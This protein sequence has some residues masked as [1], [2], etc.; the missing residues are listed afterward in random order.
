MRMPVRL[1]EVAPG[2]WVATSRRYA[3]NTTVLL[4]GH[5]GRGGR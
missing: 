3:T 1:V 5:G 2:V 4:D